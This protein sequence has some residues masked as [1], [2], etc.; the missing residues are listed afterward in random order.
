M[1]MLARLYVEGHRILFVTLRPLR[2]QRSRAK[3]VTVGTTKI[4]EDLDV[5]ITYH[6][7]NIHSVHN[8]PLNL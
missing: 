1:T 2:L 7:G 3:R 8:L 6:S 4:F 5:K